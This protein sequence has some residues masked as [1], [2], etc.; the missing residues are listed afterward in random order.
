M[1]VLK[2]GEHR[3]THAKFWKGKRE[4]F[5]IIFQPEPFWYHHTFMV[6]TSS[7][8][9][10]MSLNLDAVEG[11]SHQPDRFGFILHLWTTRS[12]RLPKFCVGHSAAVLTGLEHNHIRWRPVTSAIVLPT[13]CNAC[14][15][16]LCSGLEQNH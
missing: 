6:A 2:A 9:T 10:E 4:C 13:S 7:G 1:V 5:G 16:Q 11:K 12:V 14:F 15:L 8:G 3:M